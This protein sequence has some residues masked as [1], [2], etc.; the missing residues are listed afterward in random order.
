MEVARIAVV[1]SLWEYLTQAPT[2]LVFSYV[3]SGLSIPNLD[4]SVQPCL[5]S[6][7]PT[8]LTS[9]NP[10]LRNLQSDLL[11]QKCDCL[12]PSL[13][14]LPHMPNTTVRFSATPPPPPPTFRLNCAGWRQA[15]VFFKGSIRGSNVFQ[16][17]DC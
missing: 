11:G 10:F 7:P 8:S 4:S 2:V 9:K 6:L 16:S 13:K 17:R 14:A 5:D 1:A 12:M 15:L 3:P